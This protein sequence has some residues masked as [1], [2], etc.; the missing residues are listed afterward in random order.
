[1][2]GTLSFNSGFSYDSSGNMTGDGVYT[3][4]WNAESLLKNAHS[5]NYT[6]DGDGKRVEKSSGT[7]EKVPG[8]FSP[9]T[10]SP[11]VSQSNATGSSQG[12][13]VRLPEP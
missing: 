11:V 4:A 5:V 7:G 9:G 6:Y 2:S 3:Y 8:T 12:T 10:F 13:I 1:M